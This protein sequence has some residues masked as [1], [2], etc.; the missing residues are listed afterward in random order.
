MDIQKETSRWR[1]KRDEPKVFK[2]KLA[3]VLECANRW[4][5][6]GFVRK[7]GSDKSAEF[8]CPSLQ[9]HGCKSHDLHKFKWEVLGHPPYNPD[10][11]PWDCAIFGSLKDSE[12]QTIHLRRRRQAERAELVHNADPGILR[13]SHSP[14]CVAVGQVPQQ[15][16][17]IL[18]TNKY[19]FLL[20]GLRLV[21]SLIPLIIIQYITLAIGNA[22]I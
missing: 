10:L 17:P 1:S 6:V 15:P 18:L 8:H 12:G 4:Q 5:Y 2:K 13:D 9:G 14:P 16:G 11:S 20:L 3:G 22:K 19:W 21:S 7:S